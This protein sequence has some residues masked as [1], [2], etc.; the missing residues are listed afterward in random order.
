MKRSPDGELLHDNLID[1]LCSVDDN[2][3]LLGD[4]VSSTQ[5]VDVDAQSSYLEDTLYFATAVENPDKKLGLW[6]IIDEQGKKTKL[7]AAATEARHAE[8]LEQR[9]RPAVQAMPTEKPDAWLND[10]ADKRGT[11]PASMA[12]FVTKVANRLARPKGT[13][14]SSLLNG[15]NKQKSDYVNR[16]VAKPGVDT[17]DRIRSDD[18]RQYLRLNNPQTGMSILLLTDK[19]T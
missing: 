19:Q 10:L 18:A 17:R 15:N 14:V 13:F 7:N 4:R 8:W 6:T 12:Q 2:Y 9:F 1:E 5:D 3:D 16:L 11:E